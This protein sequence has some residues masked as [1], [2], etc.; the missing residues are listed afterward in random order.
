MAGEVVRIGAVA[1]VH[2]G[3]DAEKRLRAVFEEAA[4]KVDVLLL[5]GDLTD[6]GLP[7]EAQVLA[8]D[9]TDVVRIPIVAVL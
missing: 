1:D 9:L 4:G 8:R 7:E 2:Y 6:F 3:R 5:A